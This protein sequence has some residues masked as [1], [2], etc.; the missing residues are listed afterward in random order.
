MA[1]TELP[2]DR[3]GAPTTLQEASRL[4][5]NFRWPDGKWRPAV[6]CRDCQ[7][8]AW[9]ALWSYIESGPARKAAE[10]T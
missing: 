1:D 2:C 8:G 6:L 9:Q 7:R 10:K 3:C 5:L 4:Q